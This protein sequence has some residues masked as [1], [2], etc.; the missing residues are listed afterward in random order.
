MEKQIL[1][2]PLLANQSIKKLFFLNYKIIE[3]E[4]LKRE[5]IEF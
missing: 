1:G 2:I 4:N 3:N 5:E